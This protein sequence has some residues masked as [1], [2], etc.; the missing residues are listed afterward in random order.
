MHHRPTQIT[1]LLRSPDPEAENIVLERT[2]NNILVDLL[3]DKELTL[4]HPG[5]IDNG[6]QSCALLK[7]DDTA[8]A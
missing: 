8:A 2:G 7:A 1:L 3:P 4:T 6:Y 5:T